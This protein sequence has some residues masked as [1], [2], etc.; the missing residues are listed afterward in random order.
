MDIINQLTSD[1]KVFENMS[2]PIN[3][4]CRLVNQS[5]FFSSKKKFLQLENL[6][7]LN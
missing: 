3:P 6:E 2:D 7:F 4:Y 1:E 5:R